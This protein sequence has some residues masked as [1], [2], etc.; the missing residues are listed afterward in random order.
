MSR[1]M[2]LI[3]DVKCYFEIK[4]II[5]TFGPDLVHVH[6][7]K[8]GI[9]GRMSARS[10]KVKSIFTPHGLSYLSFTGVKRMFFF[11]VELFAKRYT[12]KILAVSN[13]EANRLV[14]EI[15][16]NFDVIDVIL[17]ATETEKI[18]NSSSAHP[19]LS[20]EIIKIGTVS[21]LTYQKNPLLL[22]EVANKVVNGGFP[23]SNK[24]HF[25][26]FGSGLHDH[27]LDEINDKISDYNLSKQFHLL[28]WSDSNSVL[29]Y[30]MELD[31]FILT[32]VFEG[33][34]L[35]LLE[36]MELGKPA[37]VSK[38][39]GN[40]DVVNNNVNGFACMTDVHFVESIDTLVNSFEVYC[41]ISNAAQQYVRK[42]HNSVDFVIKLE[43]YYIETSKK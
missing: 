33:L 40:N 2:N 9:L 35:S 25:Y 3:N 37:L 7:S 18:H 27:L 5:K 39:D 11:L 16:F 22:I 24:A 13:S 19:L 26:I 42:N 23:Y 21:R 29:K 34:P 6:S 4:K 12:D 14:Y 41:R 15:G 28:K 38:C 8:G 30:L 10:C 1:G 31:I 32:S 43:E 20:K 17:N 36:A